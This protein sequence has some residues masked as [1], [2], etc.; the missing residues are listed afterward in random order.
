MRIILLRGEIFEFSSF[1]FC[2][3]ILFNINSNAIV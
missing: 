2:L 3:K 1:L